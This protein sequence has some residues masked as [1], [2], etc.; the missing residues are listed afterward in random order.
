MPSVA[1]FNEGVADC[2]SPSHAKYVKGCRCFACRAA[3]ADYEWRRTNGMLEKQMASAVQTQKCRKR[4][5]ELQAAGWTKRGICRASG[6][7]RSSLRYLF[8]GHE[9]TPAFKNGAKK[10]TCKMS[11]EN[12]RAVMA[13][14]GSPTDAG[15]AGRTLEDSAPALRALDWCLARGMSAAEFARL[16]GIPYQ[17]VCSMKYKRPPRVTHAT[18]EKVA[19]ASRALIGACGEGEKGRRCV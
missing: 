10:L 6:M 14:P 8:S 13:L 4:V 16:T 19:L 5:L 11:L 18:V 12:Y 3:T 17:T 15:R 7:S 2:G 1:P 9:H